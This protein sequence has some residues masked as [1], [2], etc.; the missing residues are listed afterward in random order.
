MGNL[1]NTYSVLSTI[2][3]SA[4]DVSLLGHKLTITGCPTFDYRKMESWGDGLN[5]SLL[6]T[7][8]VTTVTFTAA[9][10][11]NYSLIISQWNPT[12]NKQITI[13]L[14]YTSLSSGDTATTISNQFRTLIAGQANLGVTASGTSTLILTGVTGTPLFTVINVAPSTTTISSTVT[15]VAI[16]SCT[17]A[18]PSVITTGSAHGLLVGNVITIAS[19]DDTKLLSGTYRVATVP[20]STTYTLYSVNGQTPLAASATTTATVTLVA[21]YA[22]GNYNQLIQAGVSSSLISSASTYSQLPITYVLPVNN[23]MG[24][25]RSEQDKHILYVLE[26]ATNFA[27]LNTRLFELYNAYVAGG[28]TTDP[29][30]VSMG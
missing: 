11:T 8:Q 30:T 23:L 29:K 18:S 20:S 28:T 16:A 4:G 21:Q 1:R 17:A 5:S 26:G 6:E 24:N 19:A 25:V 12:L 14:Y 22:R 9:N 13:P 2:A 15:G 3:A 27:A 7:L 10:S